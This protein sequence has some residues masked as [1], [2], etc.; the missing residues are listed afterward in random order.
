MFMARH[1]RSAR[2][3]SARMASGR[4]ALRLSTLERRYDFHLGEA[5]RAAL[6][7]SHDKAAGHS[8]QALLSAASCA[9]TGPTR[10]G[11]SRSS[12]P[13][14]APTPATAAAHGRPSP[15]SRSP[16]GITRRWRRPIPPPTR[17]R[18]S[19]CSPG[20]PLPSDAAGS[21]R[22]AISL[23][24][25]VVGMYLKAPAAD[26]EERD[27][28]L[29]RA[30]FH[31]GRC[32]LKTGMDEDGLAEIAGRASSSPPTCSTGSRCGHAEP[33]W[34]VAAPPLPPA[35]RARLGG[36]GGAGHDAA[37]GGG[38][39]AAGRDGRPDRRACLRRPR[40]PRRRAAARR[41]RG[42]Q[43]SRGP[44]HRTAAARADVADS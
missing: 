17:C 14:C 36:R 2:H 8:E 43:V 21:T 32:L 13:R 27:L 30:R 4:R 29:A 33:G 38:P 10:R 37:R 26:T 41:A 40:R 42:D 5:F 7:G 23:L 3:P 19:T 35:G 25:E 24:R 44:G 39:L 28:G 22:D 31:L 20:S 16:P 18:G 12:P 15:C 34:L 9:R 1:E 11:T 6:Q